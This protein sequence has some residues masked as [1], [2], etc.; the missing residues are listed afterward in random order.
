MARLNTYVTVGE[1]TYGPGDDVPADVADL[2][3]APGVFE[4]E[5]GDYSSLKVADLKAEIAKRNEGREEA[6]QIPFDGNKVAL[7]AALE[8]DD[9]N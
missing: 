6:D 3:N 5:D 9:N 1:T 4:D 2:I 7:V 8:A